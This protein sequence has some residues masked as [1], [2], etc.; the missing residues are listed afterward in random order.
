M[1]LGS[2]RARRESES[3]KGC[4][5][6]SGWSPTS[7]EKRLSA[8]SI[9]SLPAVEPEPVPEMDQEVFA[10]EGPD[11]E[12]MF[13]DSE[14]PEALEKQLDVPQEMNNPDDLVDFAVPES[15]ENLKPLSSEEEEEE[16]EE[17]EEEEEEDLG[18]TQE[19]ESLLPPSV[20]DQA[21][22]IAERF[23]SS[24]SRRSSL[25]LEDGKSSGFGTPRLASRSSSVLSL[26]GSE[27]G[28]AQRSSLSD[29]LGSQLTPEVDSGAEAPTENGSSV[30]G[31][32]APGPSCSAEPERQSYKKKESML[33]TRDRLLLDRI[34]TY[35]EN[36]EHHDAGFSIRRRESLS[37]IP[38]GL[39]RNS[40]SRFNNLPQPDPEPMAPLGHKRQSGSRP[41]SWALFELGPSQGGAGDSAP[42]TD[43][44]FRPSSEIVKLWEG[45]ESSGPGSPRK[46]LGPGHP[47]GFDMH[48]PLFI[49]EEHELGAITE[50]SSTA[51]PES[52]SP[53]EHRS[54]AHLAQELKEL[55]RELNGGAQ[56]ELVTPLHPRIVQLS[57]IMDGHMSERVKN[58]VYQLA[59]QYSLRIKS[60]SVPARPPLQ[61][62]KAASET[63]LKNLASPHLQEETGQL[64]G[65]RGKR[66][67]VLSL[68][69]SEP[70]MAPEH[71]SPKSCSAGETS[72]QHFSF[73]PSATSPRTTSPGTRASTRNS[74][75]PL[76]TETFSWPDVRELCSKY[77]S[78]DEAA[79][80]DGSRSRAPPVNR[81]RSVPENMMEPPRSARMGRCCSLNTKK[82]RKN[83][84]GS[85]NSP[86]QE[87]G[88]EEALYVT[89]HVTL[90]NNRR[91][92][93]MEKEPPSGPVLASE[94]STA[95]L[96]QGQDF[97]ECGPKEEDPRDIADPNQQGRVRN[98]REKFQALNSVG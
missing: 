2:G 43:A 7:T 77:A 86:L 19:P 5:S 8:E 72:P 84:R 48:E 23:V 21:S 26:E 68:F 95:I 80:G 38:K 85:E 37:Y 87:P 27:K 56:G 57:H 20:L 45:M 90:D 51:S 91:V 16:G 49:L 82:G 50:E 18:A 74:L 55:V 73:S 6:P 98:L 12:D 66:K 58:K 33:S 64:S 42:I 1:D 96:W 69:H 46:G 78:H 40:V 54:P 36:A 32:E 28:L 71:S 59:R 29:V 15:T 17:E 44:E 30:N 22:V 9:S 25:A 34:K 60:K 35:Y 94:E 70:L 76:D 65:G 13:S 14:S 83:T 31:T 89:A 52:A 10:A 92:I 11:P 4:Q 81:S 97:Q 24:I 3:S 39:V 53:T 63:D 67:P 93:I 62:E 79:M 75:S 88:R 61:W 47:N 41:A